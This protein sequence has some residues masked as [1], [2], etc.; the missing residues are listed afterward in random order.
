MRLPNQFKV[1]NPMPRKCELGRILA[2][3]TSRTKN[4]GGMPVNEEDFMKRIEKLGLTAG[5]LLALGFNLSMNP[6]L[7][8][9]ARYERGQDSLTLELASNLPSETIDL[10]QFNPEVKMSLKITDIG[11]GKVALQPIRNKTSSD[12]EAEGGCSI[13][14]VSQQSVGEAAKLKSNNE[15]ALDFLIKNQKALIEASKGPGKKVET[16]AAVSDEKPSVLEQC[17]KKRKDD[18]LD[19]QKRLYKM[20]ADKCQ[21]LHKKDQASAC[22]AQL[23]EVFAP[24]QKAFEKCAPKGNRR[25][26]ITKLD[27]IGIDCEALEEFA[28]TDVVG[29]S[30]IQSHIKAALNFAKRKEQIAVTEAYNDAVSKGYKPFQIAGALKNQLVGQFGMRLVQNRMTGAIEIASV[31]YGDNASAD[32]LGSL[33]GNP[34]FADTDE[35]KLNRMFQNDY[36]NNFRKL[37]TQVFSN[38]AGTNLEEYFRGNFTDGVTA[39][40]ANAPGNLYQLRQRQGGGN[41][42]VPTVPNFV[43]GQ[44]PTYLN[45][46][47][48]PVNNNVGPGINNGNNN[49]N[50]RI[51]N[52]NGP[53]VL[54]NSSQFITSPIGGGRW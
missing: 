40:S 7:T 14:N 32:L 31:P 9:V 13:C 39:D 15:V 53:G 19:C 37:G 46:N 16:V 44:R 8:H 26:D 6:E 33:Q 25:I 18:Q 10:A 54:M 27:E 29:S 35:A 23:D 11:N 42:T 12:T 38:V 1:L 28:S 21:S 36:Y 3:P 22:E 5:L 45:N 4:P 43:G 49:F 48:L 41:T 34:I 52:P 17:D 20:I 51:N 24:I 2:I 30:T 47:G 50:V